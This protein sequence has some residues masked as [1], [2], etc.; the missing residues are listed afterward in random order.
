MCCAS[1]LLTMLVPVFFAPCCIAVY[2][3]HL[4]GVCSLLVPI[5]HNIC[6][7]DFSD[8]LEIASSLEGV[9]FFSS[10]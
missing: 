2:K 8:S 7:F 3:F 1:K 6:L 5:G 9:F 10:K 4:L